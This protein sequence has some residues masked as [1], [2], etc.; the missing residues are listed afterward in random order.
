MAKNRQKSIRL[1]NRHDI[2]VWQDIGKDICH[3]RCRNGSTVID[4]HRLIY[5]DQRDDL[6]IIRGGK[7]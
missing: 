2:Q 1:R 4:P 7:P 3:H 5:G 6:R